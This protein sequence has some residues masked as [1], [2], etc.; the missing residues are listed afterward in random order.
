MEE[1]NDLEQAVHEGRDMIGQLAEAVH[2]G[3][4]LRAY[5]R[6]PAEGPTGQPQ[7][8]GTGIDLEDVHK[9]LKHRDS[10]NTWVA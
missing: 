6:P 2:Q 3:L 1:V 10:R 4:Q 7:R 5:P 8:D 9:A